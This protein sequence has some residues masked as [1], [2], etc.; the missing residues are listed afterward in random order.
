MSRSTGTA[1][2]LA[3]EVAP[4]IDELVAAGYPR[5]AIFAYPG[6]ASTDEINDAVLQLVP[7]VRV[8]Q[9]SCPY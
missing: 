6:G 8:G 3:D 4:S 9:G 1:A 2:Y 7:R 5:A